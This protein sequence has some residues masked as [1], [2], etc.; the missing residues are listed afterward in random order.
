[1]VVSRGKVRG[2][3]QR[4]FSFNHQTVVN[5]LSEVHLLKEM[6]TLFLKCA[7][8]CCVFESCFESVIYVKQIQVSD[9]SS[10]EC[11]Q[12]LFV[13]AVCVIIIYYEIILNKLSA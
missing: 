13:L 1:M 2:T 3:N 11:N 9:C 10:L 4:V 7:V 6:L 8:Y 12:Y 5:Y